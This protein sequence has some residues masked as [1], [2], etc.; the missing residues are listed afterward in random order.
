MNKNILILSSGRRVSLVKAFQQ[1]VVDLE[2]DVKILCADMNPNRAAACQI[3]EL[4]FS[5]PHCLEDNYTET[6][7][8]LCKKHNISMVVPTIDT[9]LKV[10]AK[11]K[12]K[13]LDENIVLVVSDYELVKKCRDKRLTN[14]M[15]EQLDMPVPVTYELDKIKFPCFSKP[16]SGS[17][18]QDIRILKSREELDTWDVEKS[19]MM[20]MEIVDTSVFSE[21][22]IDIYY[23]QNSELKCIVPRQRLEVRGGEVSKALTVKSLLPLIKPIMDKI[24]GAFGCL[25]LQVFKHN[26][27]DEIYGIEINPRF[28]GGFPLTN[29][30]GAQYPKW[31]IQ[32]VFLNQSFEY[33]DGWKDQLMMLRYD[34]EVLVDCE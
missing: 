20:Y 17:L 27:T 15:F 29:L 1:A 28:G 10:L 18:S 14:S 7:L 26:I 9:E 11:N 30:S 21:F 4:S 22:T 23:N 12:Q 19:Q 31:L 34:A 13:F 6:L 5:L 33:F 8:K 2:L 16:I 25:T 3:A 24:S 32:E